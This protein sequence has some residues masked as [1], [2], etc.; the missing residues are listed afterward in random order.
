[1]SPKPATIC[2]I[3]SRAAVALRRLS[4]VAPA[5]STATYGYHRAGVL[6]ALVNAA[7]LV[8]VSFLIFYEAFRRLQ[9]PAHVHCRRDDRRGRS[10]VVMNGVIALV[11]VSLGAGC[12]HSAARSCNEICDTL[13]TAAVI[14]GGG[15]SFH[16]QS[17]IDSGAF[18]RIAPSS[19]GPL[20]H[21]RET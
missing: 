10:G 9:A 4:A 8:A 2:L 21:R 19:Y 14:V 18:S 6:A 15:R 16:R 11:A 5:S 17:W 12:E 1:L 7:S 3:F 20:R 13:S